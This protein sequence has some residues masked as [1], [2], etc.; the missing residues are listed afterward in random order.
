[1]KLMTAFRKSM[2][3]LRGVTIGMAFLIAVMALL[4]LLIYPSYRDAFGTLELPEAMKGFLGE[5]T[6]LSSPEGFLTAEYFSWIPLLLVTLAIVGGSAAFAGEEGAGT[7][8][9]LLSQPIRRWEL[10]IAKA[11]ALAVSITIAALSGLIG[12]AIGILFVDIEITFGRLTEAV[13]YMLPLA[14]AF[15]GVALLA[16]AALSSRAAAAM[17]VTG[18]LV[19]TYF[20]QVLGGVNPVMQDIRR[21]SPFYWTD[22]SRVLL[23]G[24]D[25]LRAG[26]FVLIALAAFGL[27]TWMFERRDIF[28]GERGW[29]LP[30]FR[31]HA[32]TEDPDVSSSRLQLRGNDQER[33]APVR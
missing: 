1:M 30:R 16:S 4:D 2:R 19:L 28:T 12:F 15:A 10:A 33:P 18:Y 9:L 14:W 22:A 7:M 20:I 5:A 27:A 11:A 29:S 26:I 31:R 23:N 6:D 25:W 24:F 21:I 3:D 32:R 17:T 8:D 13:I